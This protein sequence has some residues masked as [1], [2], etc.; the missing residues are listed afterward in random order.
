MH[1]RKV[2]DDIGFTHMTNDEELG[3]SV[4]NLPKDI[5]PNPVAAG[6]VYRSNFIG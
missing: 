5:I 1:L 4:R 6:P 3:R 2:Y